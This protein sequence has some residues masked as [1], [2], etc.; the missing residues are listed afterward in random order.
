MHIIGLHIVRHVHTY[1]FVLKLKISR[2]FMP[3]HN[4]PKSRHSINSIHTLTIY[5]IYNVSQINLVI[6]L[7]TPTSP[8]IKFDL[9]ERMPLSY[10]ITF[11]S[12]IL[13]MSL[14]KMFS[15]YLKL[16][17]YSRYSLTGKCYYLRD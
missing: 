7:I 15:S 17:V 10:D 11:L 14:H 3:T 4:I 13:S 16:Y 6:M 8:H 9:R 1:I 12:Q 2:E 5:S